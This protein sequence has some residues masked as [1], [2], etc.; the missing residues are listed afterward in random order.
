M[1]PELETELRAT[2]ASLRVKASCQELLILALL[3]ELG[4]H[5]KR[6]LRE[7]LADMENA[8]VASSTL[9]DQEQIESETLRWIR[10][11]R[12]ALDE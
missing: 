2:V 9:V 11:M 1:K 5:Q 10:T 6:A 4:E 7:R 8:E 3:P 12:E